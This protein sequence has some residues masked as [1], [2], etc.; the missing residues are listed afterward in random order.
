VVLDLHE[1]ATGKK[2]RLLFSGDI[3]RG[4]NDLL[5]DPEHADG[6]DAVIMEST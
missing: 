6:V 5:R 4:T 2:R 1:F 3:G